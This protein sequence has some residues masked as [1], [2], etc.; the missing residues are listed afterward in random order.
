VASA[1]L[2]C[3][4]RTP[5]ADWTCWLERRYCLQ[6]THKT[7]WLVILGNFREREEVYWSENCCVY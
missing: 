7:F 3:Y 4:W 2:V 6:L 1:Q 5:S